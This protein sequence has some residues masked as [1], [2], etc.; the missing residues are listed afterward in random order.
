LAAP[1]AA[2]RTVAGIVRAGGWA[3]LTDTAEQRDRLNG[4]PL[5]QTNNAACPGSEGVQ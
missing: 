2:A 3:E 5:Q 1:A 4:L